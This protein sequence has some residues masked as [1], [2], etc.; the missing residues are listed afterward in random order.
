MS[1]SGQ[2]GDVPVTERVDEG[3]VGPVV[4]ISYR[5]DDV[6]SLSKAVADMSGFVA[7]LD[8]PIVVEEAARQV[9]RLS[10]A[11]QIAASRLNGLARALAA[12]SRRPDTLTF[13]LVLLAACL[14][15]GRR[16]EAGDHAFLPTRRNLTFLGSCPQLL[17]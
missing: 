11:C 17:T 13:V 6:K 1:A 16:E 10:A 9:R 15:H 2:G 8:A 3:F 4:F 14:R 5:T 12:F 7:F